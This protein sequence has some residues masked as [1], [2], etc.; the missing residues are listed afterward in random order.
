VKWQR[1][2]ILGILLLIASTT[3][4]YAED[5][6]E[7]E[8][9]AG[10]FG[11]YIWRGQ[12]LSDDPVFQPDFSGSYE[13]FT[14]GI[15]GNLETTNINRNSGEFTE[16]D[17]YIDYSVNV[18][19]VDNL[20]YSIGMIT[21]EFPID[22]SA[23]NT[24]ELYAGV[25]LD[26]LANPAVTFYRDVDE[27][28]GGTYISLGLGHSF[29]NVFDLAG[30]TPVGVDIGAILGWGNTTYNKS[31]WGAKP[32]GTKIGGEMNDLVLTVG[33]PFELAGLS[34]TASASYVTLVGDDIRKI[35]TY[36]RGRDD[37]LVAGIGFSV[38]F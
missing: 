11:K 17:Y 25:S 24:T 10:Y 30:D 9:T 34:F 21:Y 36:G 3:T 14:A 16:I 29:E 18:Q 19:G 28:K 2:V 20:G 4:V 26:V 35:D 12:N 23:D 5:V 27:V 32:N 8:F 6:V 7:F 38:G 33:F 22:G 15:W 31:Y 13:G 1:L 37:S